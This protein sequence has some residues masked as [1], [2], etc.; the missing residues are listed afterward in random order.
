LRDTFTST[1]PDGSEIAVNYLYRRISGGSGF[2]GAWESTTQPTGLKVELG[3]EPHDDEGFSFITSGSAK[4]VV[5]DGRDHALVGA[6][7]GLTL[8][9]RRNGMRTME[10]TEKNR[11]K[12]ERLREFEL[13]TDGRTL[14]ETVRIAGQTSPDVLVFE[15]E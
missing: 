3:I 11:G 5:F 15:R 6:D 4:E 9:G 1:Q 14:T 8:S 2:A 7:S 10:Y 12:V 13:S